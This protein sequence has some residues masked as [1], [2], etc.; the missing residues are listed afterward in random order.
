VVVEKTYLVKTDQVEDSVARTKRSYQAALHRYQ[1]RRGLGRISWVTWLIVVGTLLFWLFTAY[2]VAQI[3][4]AHSLPAILADIAGN[5]I[6]VQDKDN[7]I[8]TGVLIT[9]GAKDNALILQGQYWRFITPIF[10][11]AN[12][13]HVGLNMLNL[14]I[15]GV[16]LERIVGHFRFLFIY[17]VTGVVGAIASFYF[18][19]QEI[20][21]GASG[22]IFGLVG[23]YSMFVLIHRRA[24][25]YGGIPSLLWLLIIIGINLSIGLFV[26]NVDNYAHVGG[27]LSGCV[28][29]WWCTPLYRPSANSELRDVHS[30]NLS[31]PL[32]LLTILGTLVLALIALYL[33]GAKFSL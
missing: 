15:L 3:G 32:A 6:N 31:W 11:H 14:L 25:S 19:P 24:F 28:L 26:Q 1:D 33:M 21:V 17:L 29:G 23:A 20:S 18:A 7:D 12:A 13:L 8:L 22:A 10:L 16:F 5:A 2:R 27:L 30:L 9:Y 4:G